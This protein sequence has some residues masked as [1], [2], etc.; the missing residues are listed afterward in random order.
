MLNVSLF[1]GLLVLSELKKGGMESKVRSILV[2]C[3]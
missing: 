2:M 3:S 1:F